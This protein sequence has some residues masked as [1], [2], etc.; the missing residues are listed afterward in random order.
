MKMRHKAESQGDFSYFAAMTS[1]PNLKH[2]IHLA[3]IC[4]LYGIGLLQAQPADDRIDRL[5]QPPNTYVIYQTAT[6]MVIDGKPDEPV[7]ENVAWTA[8]F[9]DIEGD[10]KP[11]PLHNTRVKMLWDE[12]FLYIYAQLEEPDVWATLNQ[13]DAIIFHDNDFEV[14]IK[15][16]A[17]KNPYYEIEINALGTV[18]DLFM[19]TTYRVGGSALTTWDL[20]GLQKAVYVSGTRNDP[21]DTDQFWAV[22]MA[23]PF[24]GVSHFGQQQV[25]SGEDV[26]RINFSRVQWQHE[27]VNGEYQR[28]QGP[29]GRPLPENNWVWSPQGVVDMHYP[30]RWG[31]IR[32]DDRTPDLSRPVTFEIPDQETVKQR[33]WLVFYLQRAYRQ[34]HGSYTADPEALRRLYPRWSEV[35]G[36]STLQLTAGGDWFVAKVHAAEDNLCFSINQQGDIQPSTPDK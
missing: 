13:H 5:L 20:K 12:Q 22:E 25:P 9:V 17:Y 26:W 29:N 30:E 23:I 28:K 15:N 1:I 24:S 21:G 2:T 6:P 10:I 33:A 14:F 35:F 11:R 31:Y 32:F 16:A 8:D 18:F 4:F 7:W 3:L 34:Q 27:L 36:A 19:P